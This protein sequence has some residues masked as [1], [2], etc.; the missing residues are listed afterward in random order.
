MMQSGDPVSALRT[1]NVRIGDKRTSVRLE[2]AF[3]RALDKVARNEGM[4][5]HALCTQVNCWNEAL[6][7]TAALRVFLLAYIWTESMKIAAIAARTGT[8]PPE[9]RPRE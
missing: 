8:I 2:P 7:L 3:W 4:T 6:S 9:F 1:K 5:I